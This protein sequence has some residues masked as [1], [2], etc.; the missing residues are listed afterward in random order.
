[1][2]GK[3][4]DKVAQQYMIMMLRDFKDVQEYA[5]DLNS[6]EFLTEIT[7]SHNA[8]YITSVEATTSMG[9]FITG[10]Q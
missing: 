4:K 2:G 5:I 3:G 9:Q 10:P 7:L 8:T 6:N 1:M